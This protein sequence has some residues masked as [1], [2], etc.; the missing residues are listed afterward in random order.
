MFE[1]HVDI[2]KHLKYFKV[3]VSLVLL[4]TFLFSIHSSDTQP[5]YAVKW[6]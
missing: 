2:L 5:V 1:E 4:Y 3:M 6:H